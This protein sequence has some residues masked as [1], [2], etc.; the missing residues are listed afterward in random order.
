MKSAV[1]VE[2]FVHFDSPEGRVIVSIRV[3]EDGR[4]LYRRLKSFPLNQPIHDICDEIRMLYG[5]DVL[6][7]Q[8]LLDIDMQ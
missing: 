8:I 7:Y 2:K 4:F 3:Y 6:G 5:L 1:A